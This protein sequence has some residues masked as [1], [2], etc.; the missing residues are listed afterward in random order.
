MSDVQ[1]PS[2]FP[3]QSEAPGLRLLDSALR[4]TICSELFDGPVT[5]K[6]GH[7]FCSLCIRQALAEKQ[8]CPACRESDVNEGHLRK[9][10][11]MEEA[12]AAWKE[13]RPYILRI[14]DEN[15]RRV[16]VETSRPSKRRRLHDESGSTS[17]IICIHPLPLIL[18]KPNQIRQIQTERTPTDDLI[19]CPLCN[20]R[21]KFKDINRHLDKQCRDEPEPVRSSSKSQWDSILGSKSKVQSSKK[22]QKERV[23][24]EDVDDSLPTKS[25]D[26]LRDKAIRDLLHEHDLLTTGDRKTIVA[27]HQ[28]WVIIYNANLDKTHKM[29]KSLTSLRRDLRD[30]ETQQKNKTKHDLPDPTAYQIQQKSEF[31]MLVEAARPKETSSAIQQTLSRHGQTESLSPAETVI[32]VD[33]E[34]EN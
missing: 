31:D 16:Q 25:Y 3:Q 10:P 34:G 20:K 17:D 11:A 13:C 14:L 28:R 9:N 15:S 24:P 8:E 22:R 2:D 32:I 6:C 18:N 7:C 5:L 29:R 1:D 12:V 27:R 19:D 23:L 30:W 33:C 4:C 21:V 26:T